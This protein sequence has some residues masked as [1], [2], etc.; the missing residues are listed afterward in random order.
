MCERVT[1]V[2]KGNGS[3][4]GGRMGE[5]VKGVGKGDGRVKG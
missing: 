2:G 3:W 1:D 5:K 4:K